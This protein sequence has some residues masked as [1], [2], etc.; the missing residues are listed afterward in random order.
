[1][2]VKWFVKKRDIVKSATIKITIELMS[3]KEE[4]SKIE[5]EPKTPTRDELVKRNALIIE[6]TFESFGIY[7]RVVEVDIHKNMVH[8]SIEIALG[9]KID[10]VLALHKDLAL[11]LASPSG[12]VEME[13]P[14]KGRSLIRI[15]VPLLTN[16]KLDPEK[17]KIIRIAEKEPAENSLKSFFRLLLR[18]IIIVFDWLSEKLRVVENK[19]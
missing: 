12:D 18:L 17:Y 11:A 14:I 5:T 2:E 8:F 4:T 16:P 9:T 13:A 15:K 1:M 6:R 3:D 7:S 10:D 19:I